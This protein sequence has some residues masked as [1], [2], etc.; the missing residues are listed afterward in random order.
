M[1]NW[2]SFSTMWSQNECI[3]PAL[4]TEMV[5]DCQVGVHKVQVVGIRWIVFPC[6]FI[7]RRCTV[8]KEW[9]LRLALIVHGIKSNDVLEKSMHIWMT[10]R[11]VCGFKNW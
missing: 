2:A 7:R 3:H 8:I 10:T 5:Q 1:L 6:P 11:V 9:M 4:S